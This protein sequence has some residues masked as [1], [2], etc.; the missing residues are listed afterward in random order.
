MSP[1]SGTTVRPEALPSRLALLFVV[2][3]SAVLY[4]PSMDDFFVMDDFINLSQGRAVA[5]NPGTILNPSPGDFPPGYRTGQVAWWTLGWWIGEGSA[6]IYHLGQ[7]LIL[8]AILGGIFILSRQLGLSRRG[9]IFGMWFFLLMPLL[10]ESFYWLAAA[11]LHI[12]FSLASVICFIAWLRRPPGHAGLLAA[13]ALAFLSCQT[14]EAGLWSFMAMVPAAILIPGERSARARTWGAFLAFAGALSFVAFY[15]FLPYR[16]PSG[17]KSTYDILDSFARLVFTGWFQPVAALRKA[18]SEL[19][20]SSGTTLALSIG[21]SAVLVLVFSRATYLISKMQR[22]GER[23]RCFAFAFVAGLAAALPYAFS[24]VSGWRYL[25]DIGVWI[26]LCWGQIADPFVA[27]RRVAYALILVC[28]FLS[29]M[30][31]IAT[32]QIRSL[33]DRLG[34][35]TYTLCSDVKAHAEE[36]DRY[37]IVGFPESGGYLRVWH[38]PKLIRLCDPSV[39]EVRSVAVA[40]PSI[41]GNTAVIAYSPSSMPAHFHRWGS[42]GPGPR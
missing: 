31:V 21:A 29:V 10:T 32:H 40:P 42:P 6:R 14:K 25:T 9:A 39:S 22:W 16:Y 33:Y 11:P 41:A 18:S 26:A 37:V 12:V 1:E 13:I 7:A 20:F 38:V 5:S 28:I 23:L 30:N 27:K 3:L 4:A 19:G 36:I 24:G 17:T 8:A 15:L 2:L 34:N 35:A